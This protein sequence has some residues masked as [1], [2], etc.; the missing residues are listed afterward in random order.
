MRLVSGSVSRDDV[1]EVVGGGGCATDHDTTTRVR[2][3]L[4]AMARVCEWVSEWKVQD[5]AFVS[6]RSLD[7][8]EWDANAPALPLVHQ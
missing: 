8:D 5:A 1:M 3:L 7:N 2:S 6:R 4:G